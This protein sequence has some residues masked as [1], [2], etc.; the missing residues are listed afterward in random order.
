MKKAGTFFKITLLNAEAG[1]L[2]VS[3]WSRLLLSSYRL[4]HGIS[5]VCASHD[6][7]TFYCGFDPMQEHERR[8]REY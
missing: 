8:H 4:F 3:L 1:S 5:G 6:V 7:M 2:A